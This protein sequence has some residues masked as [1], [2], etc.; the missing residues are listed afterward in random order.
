[1]SQRNARTYSNVSNRAKN[2]DSSEQRI[3]YRSVLENPFRISWPSVTLNIQNMALAKVV[4]LLQGV[5]DFHQSRQR[6]ARVGKRTQR[7]ISRSSRKKRR[8]EEPSNTNVVGDVGAPMV[9]LAKEDS[10]QIQEQL[11]SA[12]SERVA[13]PALLKHLTVGINE[14]TKKLELLSEQLQALG[15]TNR[16]KPVQA[17]QT[18]SPQFIFVCRADVDPPALIAHLPS[19]VAACNSRIEDEAVSPSDVT[20]LVPFP[21]G[22]ESTLANHLGFRRASVISIDRDAPNLSIFDDI[23]G[24]LPSLM[25]PWLSP[26]PSSNKSTLQPTHIK[27]L[28]TTAPKDMRKNKEK[29]R[30]GLSAA[31]E[32]RRGL[33]EKS[34]QLKADQL[35]S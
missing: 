3:V 34:K 23:L 22:S 15:K 9:A 24:S 5:S 32:R 28:R 25:A 26:A 27:Q 18:M 19:L 31:R 12:D 33:S 14:V 35:T 29:R 20:L 11:E 21:P 10:A 1:M 13:P 6:E 2:K 4:T 30:A 7:E 17:T 16:S 8:L